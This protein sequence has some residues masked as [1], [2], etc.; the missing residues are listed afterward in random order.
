MY[1]REKSKGS[2]RTGGRS[3]K[4]QR[5]DKHLTNRAHTRHL[6]RA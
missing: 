3:K 5:V 6:P 1:A 2:K 4:V